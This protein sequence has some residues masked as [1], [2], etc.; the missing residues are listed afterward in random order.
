VQKGCEKPIL[1]LLTNPVV[2]GIAWGDTSFRERM[3]IS[4]QEVYRRLLLRTP[5]A[6]VLNFETLALIAKGSD[7][8][9]DQEKLR[10]LI[11]LLRPDRDGKRRNFAATFTETLLTIRFM[12]V[13][14]FR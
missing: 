3:I 6:I 2:P 4:S 9:L 13:V 12:T 11:K 7:G 5:R 10:D 8:S 14:P 1:F